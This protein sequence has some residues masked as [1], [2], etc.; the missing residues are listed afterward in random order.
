MGVPQKLLS[1]TRPLYGTKI[2][3]VRKAGRQKRSKMRIVYNFFDKVL[4]RIVL[5]HYNKVKK[6]TVNKWTEGGGL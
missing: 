2:N 5:C 6:L 4:D 3:E 1:A